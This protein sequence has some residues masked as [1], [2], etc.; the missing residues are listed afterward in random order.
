VGPLIAR[1]SML[2]IEV[3]SSVSRKMTVLVDI[4]IELEG[5]ANEDK[6]VK[7]YMEKAGGVVAVAVVE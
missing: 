3:I 7:K 1:T 6:N 5:K 2:R 4:R